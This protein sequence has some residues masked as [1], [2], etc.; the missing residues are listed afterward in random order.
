MAE[1]TI[2]IFRHT[3][4]AQRYEAG[5]TIFKA[6]DPG[7]VMFGIKEGQVDIVVNGKAV[8]TVTAGGIFGEMS[9]IEK[10]SPRSADAV[11]KTA[12]QLVVVDERQFR[13]LVQQ[14]PFFALQVMQIMA[15]RIR[16]MNAK[17]GG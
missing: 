10:A 6:G 1:N 2:G 17:L 14:H 5:Q 13:Y 11:A 12:V 3:S 15:H 4:D 9:L 16:K 7:E 8:E